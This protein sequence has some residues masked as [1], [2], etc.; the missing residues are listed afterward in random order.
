MNNISHERWF[1][2]W[3]FAGILPWFTFG[4]QLLLDKEPGWVEFFLLTVMASA[5]AIGAALIHY[6]VKLKR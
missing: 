2:M 3:F 4:M 1:K 5:G 6:N